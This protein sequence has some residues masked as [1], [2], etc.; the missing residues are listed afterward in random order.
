M[1][2]G[3]YYS[4]FPNYSWVPVPAYKR[5]GADQTWQLGDEWG[6]EAWAPDEAINLSTR[7]DQLNILA[8]DTADADNIIQYNGSTGLLGFDGNGEPF[9]DADLFQATG[10]WRRAWSTRCDDFPGVSGIPGRPVSSAADNIRICRE[11]L[12]I[13]AVHGRFNF[14]WMESQDTLRETADPC[15]ALPLLALLEACGRLI[16]WKSGVG[17]FS[18]AR[19]FSGGT[20]SGVAARIAAFCPFESE[21][22]DK[23]TLFEV[24][25]VARHFIYTAEPSHY[26]KMYLLVWKEFV[27]PPRNQWP[28]GF[29]KFE[30]DPKQEVTLWPAS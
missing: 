22:L 2:Y 18:D 21:H 5:M 28:G 29:V 11:H 19:G 6:D 13:E 10:L 3:E 9:F 17:Y 24:T 27:M 12:G 7:I 20:L 8:H 4:I 25:T 1:K 26:D 14:P 16:G 23:W 15:G 30:T